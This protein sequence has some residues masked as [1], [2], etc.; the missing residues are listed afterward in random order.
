MHFVIW[1]PKTSLQIIT[2]VRSFRKV[3]KD[4][5]KEEGICWSASGITSAR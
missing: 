1:H 5:K 2:E 3:K 4:H